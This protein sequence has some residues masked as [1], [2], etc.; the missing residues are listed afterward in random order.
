[1]GKIETI[2]ENVEWISNEKELTC[3]GH[4]KDGIGR[5][6]ILKELKN[7]PVEYSSLKSRT[8]KAYADE[9]LAVFTKLELDDDF[10]ASVPFTFKTV[11]KAGDQKKYI[12]LVEEPTEQK[13]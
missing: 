2:K 5:D 9:Y 4:F 13:I 3:E 11:E 12:F 8:G 7:A 1:M 6:F 10:L